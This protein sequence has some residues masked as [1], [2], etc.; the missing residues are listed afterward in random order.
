MSFCLYLDLRLKAKIR[1]SAGR[2]ALQEKE[3]ESL[4]KKYLE[5]FKDPLILLLL[6]SAGAFLFEKYLN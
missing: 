6:A 2:N 5:Q 3:E 1:S 4:V